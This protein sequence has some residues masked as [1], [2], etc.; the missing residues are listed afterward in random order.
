MSL[1]T[2]NQSVEMAALIISA[3]GPLLTMLAVSALERRN[4]RRI[5]EDLRV[6][7]ESRFLACKQVNGGTYRRCGERH[8]SRPSTSYWDHH[9]ER[10]R[11]L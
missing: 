1:E 9:E 5:A 4:A 6:A 3:I 8:K 10:D 7:K 2:N 11:T